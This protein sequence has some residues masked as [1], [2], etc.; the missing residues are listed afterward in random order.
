MFLVGTWPLPRYAYADFGWS[1]LPGYYR[2]WYD[3]A[4]GV[5]G[6][7]AYEARFPGDALAVDDLAA[8]MK[9]RGRLYVWGDEPWLYVVSGRRA[10]GPYVNL[11]SAWRLRADGQ[12]EALAAVERHPEY[13]IVAA[14]TNRDL[15]RALAADYDRL[16]FLPGPWRVYGLHSG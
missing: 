6:W 7:R 16:R 4:T 12:K 10:S 13:V 11:N 9:V 15:D 14:P 3:R 8:A 1:R 2:A 5:T